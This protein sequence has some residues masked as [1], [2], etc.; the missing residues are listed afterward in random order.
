[1]P[2]YHALLYVMAELIRGISA[3]PP[4]YIEEEYTGNRLFIACCML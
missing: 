1:M 4:H 2:K 3:R